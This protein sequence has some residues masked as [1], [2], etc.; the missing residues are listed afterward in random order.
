[1]SFYSFRKL[2]VKLTKEGGTFMLKSCDGN[3]YSTYILELIRNNG[4]TNIDGESFEGE[5]SDEEVPF[6]FLMFDYFD[7]LYCKELRGDEKKYLNYLSIENAF[8]DTIQ[9]SKNYKVSYKTLSLYCKSN[10]ELSKSDEEFQNIFSI[11]C[12]GENL[13]TIPFLGLIQIS[14]CKDNYIRE[15]MEGIEIDSFLEYCENRIIEIVEKHISANVRM[16]LFR[17]STTGDFCL[18]LRTDSIKAIYNVAIALNG[19]QHKTNESVKMLTF[20]NVGIECKYLEGI[21]YATLDKNFISS[22]S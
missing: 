4:I 1:M 2:V 16:Q 13:S 7:I 8:E 21:G 18:V 15:N 20:T 3:K 10:N 14:L 5:K 19:T 17:S 22:H 6:R 11:I 12:T 9:H